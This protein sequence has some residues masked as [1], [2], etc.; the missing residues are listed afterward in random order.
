MKMKGTDI[1]AL[2]QYYSITVLQYYSITVLLDRTGPG[3]EE[4]AYVTP[5]LNYD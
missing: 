1:I 3:G 4:A 2:L 5:D